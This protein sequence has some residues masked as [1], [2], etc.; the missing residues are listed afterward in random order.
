MTRETLV[1]AMSY[2]TGTLTGYVLATNYLTDAEMCCMH[3]VSERVR[4]LHVH[5]TCPKTLVTSF[6]LLSCFCL[7]LLLCILSSLYHCVISTVWL[8]S[9]ILIL[10]YLIKIAQYNGAIEIYSR[11]T[12]L[13]VAQLCKNMVLSYVYGLE[14]VSE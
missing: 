11:P 4:Y 3:C 7:W 12:K 10:S 8:H 5:V 2:S 14:S 13:A 6:V 1:E 9:L